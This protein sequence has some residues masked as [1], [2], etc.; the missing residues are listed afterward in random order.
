MNR[1]VS[2]VVAL[3]AAL[4]SGL[5]A[6]GAGVSQ[7]QPAPKEFQFVLTGKAPFQGHQPGTLGRYEDTQ[8]G[9]VCYTSGMA[10]SCVK[11]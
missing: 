5:I 8:Y 7:S 3:V 10:F 9:I 2:V 6:F 11:K 1:K 4:V